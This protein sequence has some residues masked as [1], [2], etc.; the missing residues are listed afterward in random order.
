VDAPTFHLPLGTLVNAAAVVVGSAIGMLLSRSFPERLR[1]IMF[2]ATGLATIVLGAQMALKFDNAL[3]LIFSLLLGGLTGEALNL[4]LRF[5][6]LAERIRQ[7]FSASSTHF[8]EGL[9]TAFLIYCIG[10]LTIVGA[11]NEG[12][13]GDHS[14]LLVKSLLDGLTSIA[15]AS[16]YGVGVMFSALPLLLFQLALTA[17]GWAAAGT[18]SGSVLLQVTAVGGVLVLGIGLNIVGA[19]KLRIMNL[20]PALLFA[21]LLAWGAEALGWIEAVEVQPREGAAAS[22]G[23]VEQGGLS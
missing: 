18:V 14:L 20:V 22:I 12:M 7:R 21:A 1:A 9:T 16:A 6:K 4:E 17:A 10:P 2:Q 15:L 11:L 19:T 8:T 3:L 23:E 13:T 5:E